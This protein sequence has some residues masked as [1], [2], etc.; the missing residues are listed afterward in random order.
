[1]IP[2]DSL[3]DD[4]LMDGLTSL[5]ELSPSPRRE[6]GVRVRCHKE[7]RRRA[8][9]Q[10]RAAQRKRLAVWCFDAGAGLAVCAYL[11]IVLQATLRVALGG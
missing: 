7:L 2:D 11:A 10:A 1:M 8:D 5:P 3:P 9:R 6:H 4:S